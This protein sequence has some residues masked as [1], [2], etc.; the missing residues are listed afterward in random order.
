MRQGT[1]PV[2]FVEVYFRRSVEDPGC[3][4]LC[5]QLT[6]DGHSQFQLN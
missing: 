5:Y 1:L 6:R 4:M 2:V 3:M